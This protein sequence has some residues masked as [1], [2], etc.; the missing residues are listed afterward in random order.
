MML[1]FLF[2]YRYLFNE[3][4][5]LHNILRFNWGIYFIHLHTQCTIIYVHNTHNTADMLTY[6]ERWGYVNLHHYKIPLE[7]EVLINK[8]KLSQILGGFS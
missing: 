8:F 1:E 3:S 4:K 6:S 2:F 7:Y 5:S